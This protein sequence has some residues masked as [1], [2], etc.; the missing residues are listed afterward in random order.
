M[1]DF[2]EVKKN[3]NGKSVLVFGL[4]VSGTA[5]LKALKAASIPVMIGD[6]NAQS[7]LE[8]KSSKGVE[9]IHDRN[10]DFLQ[11]GLLIL[12]PGIPLTHPE[13][14]WSVTAAKEAGVEVIGDIEL[15]SRVIKSN[16]TIGITGT[17]GKSTTVS[18]VEHILRTSGLNPQLGGNIGRP[19][20]ELDMSKD[21]AIAVLELSSFQI[22]LCPTFRP[23]ISAILNLTPDHIDRHGTMENY[24][25]VKE[26]IFEMPSA[27]LKGCAIITTDDS[28]CQKIYVKAQEYALRKITE[29]STTKELTD[30]VFVKGGIL[31][32]AIAGKVLEIGNIEEI[33][34]LRGVH[35]YQNAAVAYACARNCNL[36]AEQIFAA[37][38]SFPGLQHRQ[39]LVRAINGVGYVNDSKATNAAATAMALACH[40][41]VYWLVGGRK[42]KTGL[43]GLE[44]FFSQIKHAFLIGESI[45][46]FAQWFDKYGM[47][48]T[49][50][51]TLEK[52]LEEAHIMAQE[53]RGQPGGA[54]VVLLSPAC[55]SF[56]QYKSFEERGD[57]FS[58]LVNALEGDS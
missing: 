27:H 56:D 4:G 16:V 34:P 22:D 30:G 31:Y 45:D 21:N 55:A 38:Q 3:L 35:N 26:R 46:D 54:G 32:E 53:N 39:F 50:C 15:F 44:N 47:P 49:R 8:M 40:N 6:D 51:G 25:E 14:H 7:L 28:Y 41:N 58:A 52:A 12:A 10:I 1:F 36:E 23:D 37:M 33:R 48:Y 17:N 29:V 18:L 43:E 13:P 19:V 42:K 20:F 2:E 9:I 5:L 11:I 57:S 24:A